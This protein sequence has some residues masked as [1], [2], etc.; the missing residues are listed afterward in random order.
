MSGITS[1]LSSIIAT[2]G[3]TGYSISISSS[4]P[5][6]STLGLPNVV[7]DDEEPVSEPLIAD[8]MSRCL[9]IRVGLDI[10]DGVG[11][12]ALLGE[13]PSK[14]LFVRKFNVT[15]LEFDAE[16]MWFE[17]SEGGVCGRVELSIAVVVAAPSCAVVAFGDE[18]ASTSPDSPPLSPLFTRW[19]F[20]DVLSVSSNGFG[21]V[22]PGS[23]EVA[24]SGDG[25][26]GSRSI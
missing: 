7:D 15:L 11:G 25:S 9:A 20:L 17:E 13:A 24:R 2:V 18:R 12:A 3:S 23:E 4:S 1:L 6:A 26:C 22:G 19:R 21:L 8:P 5:T 10:L 16:I 14:F